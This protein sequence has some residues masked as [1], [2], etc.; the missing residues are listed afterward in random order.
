MKIVR[1]IF[2]VGAVVRHRVLG[3]RGVVAH[4]DA[5]FER[6][7]DWADLL[8]T[9]GAVDEPWYGVLVH[10]SSDER[11]VAES[12]LEADES[13]APVEHPGVEELFVGMRGGA[14]LRR[15]ALN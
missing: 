14:Y 6:R 9:D 3:Y 2:D 8:G 13:G 7:A 11:Y 12:G 5:E 1:P 10:G 4:V 15:D